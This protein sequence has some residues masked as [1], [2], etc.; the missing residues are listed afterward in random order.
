MLIPVC[1]R[2]FCRVRR[3]AGETQTSE[4][5]GGMCIGVHEQVPPC[6]PLAFSVPGTPRGR[7]FQQGSPPLPSLRRASCWPSPLSEKPWRRSDATCGTRKSTPRSTAASQREVSLLVHWGCLLPPGRGCR[8]ATQ[9]WAIDREQ[10]SRPGA[11]ECAGAVWRG[12]P[13]VATTREPPVNP[14]P[15]RTRATSPGCCVLLAKWLVINLE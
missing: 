6:C 14:G 11:S 9:W 15:G 4:L 7:W 10:S 5:A 8:V 12:C 3:C 13:S 1:E 2:V